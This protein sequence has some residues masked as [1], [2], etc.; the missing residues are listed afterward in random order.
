MVALTSKFDILRGWP[1]GSAVQ[2]DFIIG[3][4]STHAH[5][6]GTWVAL[7]STTDGTMKTSDAN[8]S[9]DVQSPCFLII[10]G[11]DD[12]SSR[13]SNRVTCLL[14]GG[15]V[16][17]IPQ[18]YRDSDNV[19]VSCLDGAASTFAVGG[20]AKVVDNVLS[21]VAT[22]DIDDADAAHIDARSLIVGTVLAVDTNNNTIDLYVV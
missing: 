4:T 22:G 12:L 3:G 20:R 11:R 2:E 18:N 16:V 14:G 9:S 19:L 17:R 7:A 8:C 10:E 6:A 5:K 21:P 1:N 13:F 15:Y